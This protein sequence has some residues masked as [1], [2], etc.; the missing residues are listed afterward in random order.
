MISLNG[1]EKTVK[2]GHSVIHALK[3][4]T[5][6]IE[7][8]EVFGILGRKGA[9][10]SALI[11]CIN[12]LDPPSRGAVI[13]DSCDLTTLSTEAL[14]EA[15]R[16]IGMIFQHFNLLASRTVFENVALPLEL[17]GSPKSIFSATVQSLLA[18]TGLTDKRE[19]YPHQLN[20]EQ[21]Q[22]VAI[23][24]A[25]VNRPK[26]L[27][28]EEATAAL[29]PSAKQAI[30]QLLKEINEQFNLTILMMT[31]ELDVIKPICDRVAVLH[32]GEIIEQ[33]TVLELFTRPKTVVAK[34]LIR[35]TALLD[36]PATLRHRLQPYPTEHSNPI[37]RISFASFT[38]EESVIAE[39]I[40]HFQVSVNI[41]QAHL[42]T[43]RTE[44]IGIMIAE[45]V[46]NSE[47]VKKAIQF[48]DNQDLHIEVLGYAPRSA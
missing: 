9:G 38:A 28:C 39:V 33:G 27:L 23:A 46:G 6:D 16:S 21:K 43:I 20:S 18:L 12:L 42:D 47:E 29:D 10:K 22:R 37:L 30:L 14:R 35:T 8:G 3:G 15:R 32:Q 24:R 31:H 26:V 40:Q 1:I 34:E 48:L 41:I 45:M 36:L 7:Q 17:S 11:R 2:N 25:L 19:A 5:L 4:I 44:S 13:I